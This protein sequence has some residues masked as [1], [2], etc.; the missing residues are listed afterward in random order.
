MARISSE[1]LRKKLLKKGKLVDFHLKFMDRVDKHHCQLITP[2]IETAHAGLPQSWQFINYVIKES[3]ASTKIRMITNSRVARFGASYN[4]ACISGSC[5]LN[6]SLGVLN[7]WSVYLYAFLTDLSE[8]YRSIGT[9]PQ[10]NSCRR[11]SWFKDALDPGTQEDFML[12]VMTYGDS[13]AGNI[14][15]QAIGIIGNDSRVSEETQKFIL[16][17]FYVEDGLFS[18]HSKEK[19]ER[20]SGELSEA[21]GRYGFNVKHVIKSWMDSK[22][23]TNTENIE[24]ILGLLWNFQTDT[25]LP[26]LNVYLCKKRKG[27]HI[28]VPLNL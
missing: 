4:D 10:K 21:F 23:V 6:S 22:G 14:L 12:K 15:A 24:Q 16:N 18:S 3:S 25:L 28:D 19:L 17:S 9:G 7:G 8:A 13:P 5:L 27:E 1:S 26:N 20:I 11:F 2:E